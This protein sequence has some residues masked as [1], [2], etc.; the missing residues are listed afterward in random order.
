MATTTISTAPFADHIARFRV[1][2]LALDTFPYGSHTTAS[3]ALWAGCPIVTRVGDTFASR[4]AGSLLRAA[5]CPGLITTSAA[6]FRERAIALGNNPSQITALR[7]QLEQ[8][9]DS[10]SLFDTPRFARDLEAAYETMLS[11]VPSRK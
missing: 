10:C 1:A 6:E 2:D 11:A 9:R 4:V 3:E 8:S 5:G 7:K